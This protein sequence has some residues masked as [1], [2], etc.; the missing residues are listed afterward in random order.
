VDEFSLRHIPKYV[1][2]IL[3]FHGVVTLQKPGLGVSAFRASAEKCHS[4]LLQSA[5]T[6]SVM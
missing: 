1:F 6:I 3:V 2:F 5:A 4:V